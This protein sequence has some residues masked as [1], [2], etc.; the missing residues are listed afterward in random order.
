MLLEHLVEAGLIG[1]IDFVKSRALLGDQ[2]DAIQD[3]L[4]R[5][6]EAV[7]DD[8]V[9][10]MLEEGNCGERAD[11]ASAT[12]ELRVSACRQ[13]TRMSNC[14]IRKARTHP[15]TRTVPTAIAIVEELI[16]G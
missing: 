7:D 13:V 5:V 9:V 11:V 2:L 10:A 16:C 12:A 6:V 1:D 3:N 14:I 4:G 15:Q 8:D